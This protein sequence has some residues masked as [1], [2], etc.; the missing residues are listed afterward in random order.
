MIGV[1]SVFNNPKRGHIYNLNHT[2]SL[3][4]LYTWVYSILTWKRDGHPIYLYC[5]KDI[6]EFVTYY[7]FAHLYDEVRVRDYVDDIHE[8][9]WSYN[10][11][12]VLE[13]I[14]E[15]VCLF[16]IDTFFRDTE[17]TKLHYDMLCYHY[18]IYGDNGEHFYNMINKKDELK[19]LSFY[20]DFD[21]NFNVVNACMIIF[22]SWEL[23]NEFLKNAK[24]TVETIK[25][26]T[27]DTGYEYDSY[28]MFM[29]Q[30]NLGYLD[31]KYD[32]TSLTKLNGDESLWGYYAFNSKEPI[33]HLGKQKHELNNENP[34][35]K[36]FYVEV[37]K[38][39]LIELG[40][41]KHS[42]LFNLTFEEN[43]VKN[44]SII[45]NRKKPYSRPPKDFIQREIFDGWFEKNKD[46]LYDDRF[47][48]AFWGSIGGRD[49]DLVVSK[50]SSVS[51]KELQDY[52]YLLIES[53]DEYN[54]TVE[55]LY[56]S[57]I[58]YLRE[59][60]LEDSN[61]V[62]EDVL[63]GFISDEP[64]A[65]IGNTKRFGNIVFHYGPFNDAFYKCTN[66]QD[67]VLYFDDV[68]KIKDNEGY[69]H[70][71]SE[72]YNTIYERFGI[73]SIIR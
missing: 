4:E 58:D 51:L 14:H 3:V 71:S 9:F 44:N 1:H 24:E 70:F 5:D 63:I 29:E 8:C 65:T 13:E 41:S 66:D 7:G 39:K 49:I 68:R 47:Q 34:L 48:L 72:V 43:K 35:T 10:K 52:M 18:E 31:R 30:V 15:P 59:F 2:L 42:K 57:D 73:F 60:R 6:E 26:I 20:E 67:D 36:T 25:E 19:N 50:N 62:Y 64:Y 46:L 16:D 28:T 69:T 37:I 27:Y 56:I 45:P 54:I 23:K 32:C 53:G 55:P 22:N 17:F 38:E 40:V 33:G 21:D 12:R 11:L 61:K